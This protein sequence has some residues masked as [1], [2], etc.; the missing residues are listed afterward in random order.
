MNPRGL[1][2][3]VTVARFCEACCENLEDS[4]VEERVSA[5]AVCGSEVK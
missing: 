4:Y 3:I 5:F 1:G 2:G